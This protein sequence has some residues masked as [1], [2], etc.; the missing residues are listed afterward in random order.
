M[1]KIIY[2]SHIIDKSTLTY[3][4]RNVFNIEKKSS[5][6]KGDIANDSF[7]S[8]T[9]H[10]G[11][12]IDM[13]FHFY[14]DGQTIEDFDAKFWIFQQKEIL[15]VEL[16]IDNG[17]LIIKDKLINELEKAKNNSP[18]SILH[19][20]LL[21][22]KTGI[23]H[24]RDKREFWEKNYGFHPDIAYYLRENFP[25]IKIFGFDSIS[26]SS[27]QDRKL[28][29]AAHKAFLDP[30]NP[31]LLLEDMNLCEVNK[32]TKFKEIVIA[33]LRIAKCDGLPCTVLCEME[34]G[35]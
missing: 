27:W 25:N 10:I 35:G 15:F 30:K 33:P 4:N 23:C 34:N 6:I 32:D 9:V 3:G 5:I 16:I 13:P 26:I 21:I 28:G 19:F 8:T 7:I 2:L 12:H 31:I 18:F 22:V 17:K 29:R 14:E 24:K 20:Q 1:S 11:T